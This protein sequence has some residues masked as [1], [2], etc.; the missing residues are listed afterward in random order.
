M[1]KPKSSKKLLWRLAFLTF[2]VAALSDACLAG[3]PHRDGN[4]GQL[5]ELPA[6][7]AS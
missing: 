3:I 2:L 5:P 1:K 4:A 7:T 6:A